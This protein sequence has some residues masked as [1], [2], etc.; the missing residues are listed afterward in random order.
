MF[1]EKLAGF[2]VGTDF[3]SI[4]GEAV[5]RAKASILDCL[6]VMVAGS[7]GPVGKL[8]MQFARTMGGEPRSSVIA[9]G[10]KTSA[11]NA[12]LANGTMGHA[13]DYDDDSD[14][15][16]GHPTVTILPAI[17]ALGEDRASGRDVLESYILGHEVGARLGSVLI[18]PHYEKGWHS[19]ST[20]GAI[21]AAA[22]SAKILKLG[23]EKT[24]MAFG[25]AASEASGLRSNFGTM[26]KPLH[27]GSAAQK[28]VAA[29]LLAESG[30]EAD[31]DILESRFGFINVFD[32]REDVDLEEVTGDL[33]TSYD[34]VSPGINIKKYPCC[35]NTH[36]AID[37]LLKLVEN[38]GLAPHD[39]KNIRC[40]VNE[41][42]PGILIH[43]DP[44]TG[45]EAKFSLP[46]CLAVALS[47]GNV[48]IADFGDE[49]IRDESIRE[50]MKK[51][52]MY[53]H[54]DLKG[55]DTLPSAVIEVETRAG[56]KHS[57]RVDRPSGSGRFP[58]TWDKL[59]SKFR[60]CSS[61]VM[62]END[63]DAVIASIQE[64]ESLP[65]IQDLMDILSRKS[66]GNTRNPSP[67]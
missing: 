52:E 8:I 50:H 57:L 23:V 47:K 7:I 29:A 27:A 42:S 37:G 12:A 54:S 24:R 43:P 59:V 10:F 62:N 30:F 58:L 17:L 16:N 56:E 51:V 49:R 67:D 66:K 33:G 44:K 39:V 31:G 53:V 14:T 32:G 3:D 2:V 46:Y 4:P 63:S 11:P 1:T 41:L 5:Q 35:Y 6:G 60:D 40:G 26:V 34:I 21:T 25:I 48:G 61:L 28:G 65:S 64:L 45:L 18:P 13:L 20:L 15:T 55:Q 36:S 19:T 22:A 9:G 38:S